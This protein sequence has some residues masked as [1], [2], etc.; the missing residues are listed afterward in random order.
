MDFLCCLGCLLISQLSTART[1]PDTGYNQPAEVRGSYTVERVIEPGLLHSYGFAIQDDNPGS[2]WISTY[3]PMLSNEYDM[4]RGN[5]TGAAWSIT[6]GVDPDDI[7]YC[8]YPGIPNQ[9][10]LG[11]YLQGRVAVFE[12]PSSGDPYF[13]RFIS[14]PSGWS[15]VYG[16]AAGMGQLFAS[17]G[18]TL[19]AWGPYTGTES[20]VTWTTHP[21][22]S[23]RGMAV[24]ENYLFVVCSSTGDNLFIYELDPGG[25]PDT[26][27]IWSCAFTESGTPGGVD[28]DGEYLWIYQQNEQLCQLSINWIPTSLERY[29]WASIKSCF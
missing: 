14:A 24:W 28:Y 3:N 27:P 12:V 6:G 5:P 23:S 1:S 25:V 26:T 16:V 10:F 22:S 17:N 4:E 29:T 8:E 18:S 21:I 20:S 2:M 7:A 15:K 19:M 11:C 13:S 9:F